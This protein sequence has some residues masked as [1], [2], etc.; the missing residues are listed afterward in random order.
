MKFKKALTVILA[1]SVMA[2]S[3]G[4]PAMAAEQ[5]G[6]NKEQKTEITAANVKEITGKIAAMTE[7]DGKKYIDENNCPMLVAGLIGEIYIHPKKTPAEQKAQQVITEKMAKLAR[8]AYNQLSEE[9]KAAVP[10]I[11]EGYEYPGAG[12]ADYFV[13]TGDASKDNPLNTAPTKDKEIIVA[14][15]GTSYTD[16]RIKTIGG[17]EKAITKAYPKYDVRRAFTSQVIINHILARDEEHINTIRESLEQ[18][19]K[20]GVKE[21]IIQPTTLMSGTEYDLLVRDV[22]A[23][24]KKGD[25]L[26]SI[27]KPL[28]NTDADRKAVAQNITSA[29]AKAAGFQS[30]SDAKDT[31]FVFMG[32]GTSHEAKATYTVMQK[33]YDSLGYKN[34]F[35]GT[36]E[37][38]PES[39]SLENTIGKV[40]KS[41]YKNVVLRPLMVVAGDHANND[42]A[43]DDED[44]WKTGFINKGFAVVPQI[45]GLGEI[46]EVQ[47]I[48]VS[49][50]KDAV[51]KLDARKKEAE[52]AAAKKAAA[53]KKKAA[54]KKAARAFKARKVGGLKVKGKKKAVKVTFKKVKGA[55]SYTV[56]YKVGK[57]KKWK[58]KTIKSTKLTLKAKSRKKVKVTVKAN[59]KIGGKKY[60]T[61][62][63]KSKSAKT[64]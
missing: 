52:R 53:A 25:M 40:K 41:G 17:I 29:A 5:S 43:G 64:R 1:A 63:A 24:V 44:S 13:S 57:A 2:T 61:K 55:K 9:E 23:I 27:A 8:Y 50:V 28:L 26:V 32:H 38:E 19:K 18:A 20:A 37:G 48:Y 36:V 45:N 35:V 11:P 49:H 12:G 62:Y 7:K 54:E 14:S 3:F 15:F 33:V 56:A 21:V 6:I 58:Y 60:S 30:V 39:T 10:E 47:Q 4:V 34:V 59:T 42:M 46:P 16:S 22:N 31:A 51:D